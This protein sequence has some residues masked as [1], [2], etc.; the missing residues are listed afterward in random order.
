[1]KT[2]FSTL[3][4]LLVLVGTSSGQ[5]INPHRFD[6]VLARG[7][8]LQANIVPFAQVFVCAAPSTGTPCTP[9]TTIYYDESLTQPVAQPLV[10][11]KDGNFS[12]YVPPGVCVDEFISSPGQG[13]QATFNICPPERTNGL[14][15]FQGRGNPAAVLLATDVAS[16]LGPLTNCGTTG[17]AYSPALA[18]C[19]L[20]P[21]VST[22]SAILKGNGAGGAVAATPGTDYP[23]LATANT[24]T[25]TQTFA[26]VTATSVVA[27]GRQV[28][29][30]IFTPTIQNAITSGSTNGSVLIPP[31][32][33]GSDTYTNTN[34]L[35]I[36]DLRT[37]TVSAPT[38][39]RTF[40]SPQFYLNLW[41]NSP[42]TNNNSCGGVSPSGI[43]NAAP[44][45]EL[46]V[47]TKGSGNVFPL[48]TNNELQAGFTGFGAGFGMNITANQGSVPQ[49][50]FNNITLAD[51]SG[52]S[53]TSCSRTSNVLTCTVSITN[54]PMILT[55]GQ[56]FF[57]SGNSIFNS[58][59]SVYVVTGTTSNTVSATSVGANA[60]PGTGGVLG[61]NHIN[62]AFEVNAFNN[63]HDPG[64]ITPTSSQNVTA[65]NG[66]TST[67]L[68][69]YPI[70]NGFFAD[71]AMYEGFISGGAIDADF[72]AGYPISGQTFTGS[73][74]GFEGRP[75]NV[76][77][78]GANQSSRG[79]KFTGSIWNGSGSFERNWFLQSVPVSNSNN[80]DLYLNLVDTTGNTRFSF[81]QNQILGVTTTA[82]LPTYSYVG[83]PTSGL[84]LDSGGVQHIAVGGV[85]KLDITS[86]GISSPN[87][88]QVGT[89]TVGQAACIKAAGPPVVIGYCSTAPTAGGTCTPCN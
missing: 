37:G 73:T 40:S 50:I 63:N 52:W 7:Q 26:N 67:Q 10:A 82:A 69:A 49:Q 25:A 1:M 38:A 59:A 62:W 15:T 60:G 21:T 27:N 44:Q 57:I 65:F 4:I 58:G 87:T 19:L 79:L 48:Y 8:G 29:G 45:M 85:N 11:D 70:S 41:D 14:V 36:E 23:G 68:G 24:F 77:T 28:A 17:A 20:V 9:A 12:Y 34:D 80:S 61:P 71:G 76:A 5:L 83:S 3:A 53:I 31:T 47:H 6:R 22:T 46:C 89:P 35:P 32:Y 39:V 75:Y 88:P 86:S 18:G 43:G 66:I 54:A 74:V 78:N 13:T 84:Y 72:V 16:V 42:Q 55:A 33:S 2:L 64:K 30:S 81:L 51:N 56:G